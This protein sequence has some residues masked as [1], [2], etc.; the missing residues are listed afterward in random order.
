M[1]R[2]KGHRKKADLAAAREARRIEEAAL[3]VPAAAPSGAAK[4]EAV[5]SAVV[6]AEHPPRQTL[7]VDTDKL[8]AFEHGPSGRSVSAQSKPVELPSSSEPPVAHGVTADGGARS[9]DPELLHVSP[10][11]HVLSVQQDPVRARDVASQ[12][13]EVEMAESESRV[14]T[15]PSAGGT[16]EALGATPRIAPAATEYIGMIETNTKLPPPANG[17]P[18]LQHRPRSASCSG[19]LQSMPSAAGPPPTSSN[20]S[21][22]KANISG[23]ISGRARSSRLGSS[24]ASQATGAVDHAHPPRGPPIPAL[25]RSSEDVRVTSSLD[26]EEGGRQVRAES[27]DP[28]ALP[29]DDFI[30]YFVK[31]DDPNADSGS[32]V[33]FFDSIFQD[34]GMETEED[35][36]FSSKNASVEDDVFNFIRV[37][38]EV[39]KLLLF[40]FFLCCD[41]LL[42]VL[43]FLPIRILRAL[44]LLVCTLALPER[45]N[46]RFRFHRT[47]LYDLLRGSIIVV[48]FWVLLQVHMSRIYHYVRGQAFIKLYVIFNM[49]DIFDRLMC[50]FGQDIMDSLFYMTKTSPRAYGKIFFR[51]CLGVVYAALHSLLY[52]VRLITLNAAI[53]STSNALMTILISNNFVELK[54]SVFKRF[55]EQ[56][57]FQITCSDM[58]ERFELFVFLLL[59]AMQSS[60]TWHDFFYGSAMYVFVCELL[61]D[62]IKHAFITKFNRIHFSCYAHRPRNAPSHMRRASVPLCQRTPRAP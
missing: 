31:E 20:L 7:Q 49:L 57:L 61:V 60:D 30:R 14:E 45:Y 37:P 52:F 43:V 9:P 56:N 15:T 5:S 48:A 25:S 12:A 38:L 16:V 51:F 29:E 62:W 24:S 40:G 28:K 8:T 47:Q 33:T 50:S 26:P 10:T 36:A 27:V 32:S 3:A 4:G 13:W 55:A 39:E 59:T 54:G 1:A 34:L 44:F 23:S 2:K 6:A 46:R 18:R 58:V 17:A 42:F 53:N 22:R 21:L 11:L 35:Q 19:V 41:S